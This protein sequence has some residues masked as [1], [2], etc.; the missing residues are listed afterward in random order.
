MTYLLD[1]NLLTALA[2]ESHEHHL[3]AKKWFESHRDPFATCSV[4]EGTLLR[5][6]MRFAQDASASAAWS[7][8]RKIRAL[9]GHEF[10]ADAF[11]YEEVAFAG[12][13]GSRQITDAWLAELAR[14]YGGRIATLDTG[15]ARLQADVALLIP[16]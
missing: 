9:A 15:L 10:W 2:L 8:L 13:S 3:R 6:H 14:R 4:T 12:I 1:G 7:T 16:N 5:L 11:S